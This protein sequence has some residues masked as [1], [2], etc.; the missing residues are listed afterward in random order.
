M[1]LIALVTA[2]TFRSLVWSNKKALRKGG[3]ALPHLAAKLKAENFDLDQDVGAKRAFNAIAAK[4]L[5]TVAIAEWKDDKAHFY[6]PCTHNAAL[7]AFRLESYTDN[8]R[9]EQPLPARA[10]EAF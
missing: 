9:K 6:R 3:L 5:A 4:L 10:I 2:K 1:L 8:W 7:V